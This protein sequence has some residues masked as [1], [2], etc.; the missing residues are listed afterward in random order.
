MTYAIFRSG[1]HQ[2]KAETG[3]TVRI[4][5]LPDE[6]GSKVTFDEILLARD[7]ETVHAGQPLVKGAKVTGEVVRHGRGTKIRVFRYKRRGGH[8][9]HAG[10][11]QGFTEVRIA[12]VKVG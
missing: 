4:P 3:K 8:R 1:G 5:L 12:A 6:P 11:R 10:H 9:K 2:F 7:G